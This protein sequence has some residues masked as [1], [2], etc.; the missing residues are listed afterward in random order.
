M[1]AVLVAPER[2]IAFLA[3]Q[4]DAWD[5]QQDMAVACAGA[6]IAATYGALLYRRERRAETG[7]GRDLRRAVPA[8]TGR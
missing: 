7:L 3:T 5:T 1:V 2:G 8:G 4:G 6:A